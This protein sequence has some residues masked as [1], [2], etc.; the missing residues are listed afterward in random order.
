MWLFLGSRHSKRVAKQGKMLTV[1]QLH[2]IPDLPAAIRSFILHITSD[3]MNSHIDSVGGRC[4]IHQDSLPVSYLQIWKKVWIQT[5]MYHHPHNKLIPYTINA[6]PPSSAW[7]Y[8]Q[9]NS[10]IF[11][12]DP[13]K[14]WPQSA[15]GKNLT[16]FDCLWCLWLSLGAFGWI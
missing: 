9:F 4:H 10:V 12:V 8:G 3:P 5:I 16:C 7:P 15:S 14:K 13:S 11:N 6:A 2:N 1:A